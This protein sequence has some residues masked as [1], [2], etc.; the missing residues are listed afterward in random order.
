MLHWIPRN[1]NVMSLLGINKITYAIISR[2][3]G[4]RGTTEAQL[5]LSYP[6]Q[7]LT[8]RFSA[9]LKCNGHLKDP[10]LTCVSK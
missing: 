8:L 2:V 4:G 6:S 5:F 10:D 1:V 7:M 9:Y 3:L